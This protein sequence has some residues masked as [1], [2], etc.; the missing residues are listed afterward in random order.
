MGRI[1]LTNAPTVQEYVE[2]KGCS[3]LWLCPSIV[4]NGKIGNP[5]YLS[6]LECSKNTIPDIIRNKKVRRH[7]QE[8]GVECIIWE[9]DE[10]VP[11]DK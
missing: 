2:Q 4:S 11:F 8:N 1:D 5:L 9:N 7:Y 6:G 10:D 3:K